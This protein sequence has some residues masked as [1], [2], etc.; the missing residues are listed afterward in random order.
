MALF[1]LRFY[2]V[3]SIFFLYQAP[4]KPLFK[5]KMM[6][7]LMADPKL[8]GKL[9]YKGSVP[10]SCNRVEADDK[11]AEEKIKPVPSEIRILK[12]EWMKI[13][14]AFWCSMR[15]SWGWGLVLTLSFRDSCGL[16]VISIIWGTIF[17]VKASAGNKWN[18]QGFK[19][20]P[21]HV[22]LRKKD[23]SQD[24]DFKDA[25]AVSLPLINAAIRDIEKGIF[26]KSCLLNIEVPTSP[27]QVLADDDI[28]S[29]SDVFPITLTLR[30]ELELANFKHF[31][32]SS[33]V[34]AL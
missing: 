32:K 2:R 3:L 29:L 21:S 11:G 26:P 24:S 25:V 34:Q 18:Q 1:S 15:H 14:G 30:A 8:E 31:I 28:T 7:T 5:D 22:L 9:P 27:L 19:L 17:L 33:V 6:F 12:K 20:W 10:S 13:I 16:C 23:E 4:H